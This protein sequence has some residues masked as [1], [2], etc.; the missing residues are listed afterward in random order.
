MSDL[1]DAQPWQIELTA[2]E[3]GGLAA[4]RLVQPLGSF[5][6]TPASRV[7]LQAIGQHRER[8]VGIGLDWGT[9]GGAL[10]IAAAQLAAVER[11]IGLDIV[12]ENVAAA[13]QNA[14]L[15][16]VAD[17]TSFFLA[18][19]YRPTAVTDQNHLATLHGQLRFILANPPSSDG[20]DGFGFRRVVL[21]EGR[22]FLAPG[23]VVFLSISY[24]YGP[25]RIAAL[26]GEIPGYR[27]GGVL[28]STG[29]VP[30]DLRR[31]DLRHCLALYAEEEARG[32]GP[33]A[34][35]APDRPDRTLDARA[36]WQCFQQT[37]QS[38]LTRWQTHL[39]TFAD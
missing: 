9:G 26:A 18:D 29:W 24:Q 12:P 31:D 28:S 39:F 13:R 14:V 30:F 32:G 23:G 17:K 37:G 27:Y 7:A 1:P 10:A 11:V 16:N 38:P 4:L 36:A 19:S 6:L 35:A 34:F 15:N 20:D 3:T 5:G 33:Y 21:A 2:A 22:P 25:Q 8:L